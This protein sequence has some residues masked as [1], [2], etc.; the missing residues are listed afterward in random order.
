MLPLVL[1]LYLAIYI[2]PS[3]ANVEKTIFIAPHTVTLP[4][5]GD[6]TFDRILDSITPQNNTLRYS[7]PAAFVKTPTALDSR[8]QEDTYAWFLLSHLTPYQRYEL[9]LCWTATVSFATHR[10]EILPLW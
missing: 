10:M 8:L 6:S 2:L 7:L 9:R 5:I 1:L 3:S 4:A